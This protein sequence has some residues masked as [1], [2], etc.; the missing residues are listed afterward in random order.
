MSNQ[1]ICELESLTFKAW[2]AAVT[3]MID[4][5]RIRFNW[6]VTRRANSVWPNA[7]NKRLELSNKLAQVEEFYA[8]WNCRARFQICPAAQPANL[9]E[10]LVARGYTSDARTAVQAA[11][12]DTVLN[13]AMPNR[14]FQ[15]SIFD[16][17]D[18]HWFNTYCQ[19][20]KFGKE[21]ALGRQG[22]LQ[23]IRP[24]TA[25]ALLKADGQPVAVGLVVAEQGWS[26]IFCMAPHHDFRR[27]GAAT[28][29][30]HA[31][32]QWSKRQSALQMYLQVMENNIPAQAL[33]TQAGFETIYHYHYREAPPN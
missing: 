28:T 26:G 19:I 8:H 21:A 12:L 27:Q 29:I 10:I 7:D 11:L 13:R 31:L 14:R 4:G 5:W 3:R 15:V 18:R 23:R 16:S 24:S 30:L 32:A 17:F 9:D 25:Y 33:Y 1:L 6:K 20:E 2:P 22:I